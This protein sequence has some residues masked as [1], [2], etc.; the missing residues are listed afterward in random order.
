MQSNR[1][2]GSINYSFLKIFPSPSRKNVETGAVLH[3]PP[4]DKKYMGAVFHTPPVDKK[5]KGAV[6]HTPPAD[7]KYVQ[8][9]FKC[10]L[11]QLIRPDFT[12]LYRPLCRVPLRLLGLYEPKWRDIKSYSLPLDYLSS[13]LGWQQDEIYLRCSSDGP[14]HDYIVQ[15][16]PRADPAF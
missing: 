3:T 5:Y 11:A 12:A 4:L 15:M 13:R 7:K 9:D 14:E 6:F 2:Y 1:I 16:D 8:Y 10:I